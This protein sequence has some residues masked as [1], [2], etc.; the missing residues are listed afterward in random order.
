M[1]AVDLTRAPLQLERRRRRTPGAWYRTWSRRPVS[2]VLRLLVL[3]AAAAALVLLWQATQVELRIVE[4]SRLAFGSTV[5]P[6]NPLRFT[7]HGGGAA[8]AQLAGVSVGTAQRD[9]DE[10]HLTLPAGLP[11]G[12]YELAV[13]VDR[14]FPFGATVGRWTVVIDDQPPALALEPAV[15][16]APLDRPVVLTGSVEPGATVELADPSGTPFR[17]DDAPAGRFQVTLERPPAATVELIATDAAGNQH[18]LPVVVP[19]AYPA[20]T[21]AAH[22]TAA[23]WSSPEVREPFLELV[24]RGVINTV[25]LDIKDESGL[26]GYDSQVPLAR[27]SGAVQAYY[28]PRAAIEE[29]HRRGVRVIGRIVAFR[30]PVLADWAWASGNR[31]WVLQHPDGSRLDAYGGFTNYAEPAVRRYNLD[32]AVEAAGLGFDE[33]LWD[34]VRRPEGDPSEMVVPGLTGTERTTGDVMVQFLEEAR[35]E[36]RP[37]GVYQGASV[38]GIAATRPEN[39]G[40][41]VDRMAAVVDYVAP[42]VYPSHYVPGE[43]GV[44]DPNGDPYAIVR[45]S[46]QD[47]NQVMAGHPAVLVPWLQDFS[48]DGYTYGA[49]EVAAQVRAAGEV[50]AHGFL[51]WNPGASYTYDG[52]S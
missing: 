19:T 42:M 49:A 30:D 27:Q 20:D 18:R 9:G 33:I 6:D 4:G 12:A 24:D 44:A 1:L 13:S 5:A 40:Q 11:E 22:I 39:I 25:Q 43:C 23:G 36:L 31:T 37:L 16:P 17:V 14:T 46:L 26:I 21:R 50:G 32:L 10:I 29:L 34:Y 41:P 52:R 47:F 35:A 28:E 38:F 15:A 8:H 3:V 7:V 45:C 2:R 51:L 48:L